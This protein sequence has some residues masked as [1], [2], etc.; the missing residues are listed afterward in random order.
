MCEVLVE[1][2]IDGGWRSQSLCGTCSYILL[3]S[4]T[5]HSL[6]PAHTP[7]HIWINCNTSHGLGL[8]RKGLATV[9]HLHNSRVLVVGWWCGGPPTLTL[10]YAGSGLPNEPL[11]PLS[12]PPSSNSSR[13]RERGGGRGYTP[14]FTYQSLTPSSTPWLRGPLYHTLHSS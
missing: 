11:Y 9:P 2:G 1:L 14:S 4:V 3:L 10:Q 13:G 12:I 6:V 7:T 5:M 8:Y